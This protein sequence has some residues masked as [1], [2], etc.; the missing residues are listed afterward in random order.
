VERSV[1]S[2]AQ[3]LLRGSRGSQGGDPTS[4]AHLEKIPVRIVGQETKKLASALGQR[5]INNIGK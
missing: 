2:L 5:G 3:A 4:P 1:I